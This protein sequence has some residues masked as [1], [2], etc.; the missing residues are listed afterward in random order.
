M[1]VSFLIW[2]RL[3]SPL[4]VK[5]LREPLG[6]VS[7]SFKQ[8]RRPRFASIVNHEG[9]GAHS[10]V[11]KSL[12]NR[13]VAEAAVAP[14]ARIF[15]ASMITTA[16]VSGGWGSYTGA[17]SSRTGR[18]ATETF[19]ATSIRNT[20]ALVTKMHWVSQETYPHKRRTSLNCLTT[21]RQ[22]LSQRPPLQTPLRAGFDPTVEDR[23]VS[24]I[25]P[26]LIDRREVGAT[27]THV[28]HIPYLLLGLLQLLAQ[29][30]HG[31]L[32]LVQPATDAQWKSSW[33]TYNLRRCWSRIRCTFGISSYQP[34][35]F[36]PTKLKIRSKGGMRFFEM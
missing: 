16:V 1:V 8:N 11:E 34:R 21:Q 3:P 22:P 20:C 24:R 31:L 19:A 29:V 14:I 9:E 25:A 36:A 32:G 35:T 6:A 33:T 10:S 15:G 26:D 7:P 18:E 23:A 5:E 17:E 30:Q 28:F 27:P 4:M 12:T 2:V 13:L